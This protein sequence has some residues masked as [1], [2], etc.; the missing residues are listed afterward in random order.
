MK[1]YSIDEQESVFVYSYKDKNWSVYSNVPK[2]IRRLMELADMEVLERDG[3]RP[4]AV[5]GTLSEK[6]IAIRKL[7]EEMTEEQ[8]QAAAERMRKARESK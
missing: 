2:H 1:N 7:R 6:H 3:D 4:I 5:K 8:K